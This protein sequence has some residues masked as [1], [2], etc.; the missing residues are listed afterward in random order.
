[1][2]KKHSNPTSEVHCDINPDDK[3]K[4]QSVINVLDKTQASVE[5]TAMNAALFSNVLVRNPNMCPE[6]HE[7]IQEINSFVKAHASMD[8]TDMN[9]TPSPRLL[10]RYQSMYSERY[11]K[12]QETENSFHKVKASSDAADVNITPT[13]EIFIKNQWNQYS[14]MNIMPLPRLLVRNQNMCSERYEKMQETA[15]SLHKAQASSD[16]TDVN[17]T[18]TAERFTTNQSNF[19]N[20]AP[21]PRLLVQKQ[22]LCSERYEKMQK[23]ENS[24]HEAQASSDTTDLNLTPT[25]ECFTRNKSNFMKLVEL[26]K[27]QK[28][29]DNILEDIIQG[30]SK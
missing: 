3:K 13:T 7:K 23:T 12:M 6:R 19:T 17:L 10:N 27:Q 8:I 29:I 20:I 14:F 22:I 9:I 15:N 24:F 2:K 4:V 5:T 26:K 30:A 25:A 1:M 11:A 28:E 21:F 18:P 16:T